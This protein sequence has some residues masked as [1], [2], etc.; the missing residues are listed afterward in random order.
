M[1]SAGGQYH[2][3]IQQIFFSA[4]GQYHAQIQK[5]FFLRVVNIM[6]KYNNSFFC[7]WS[8]SCTN[9]TTLFSAGGQYHAQIR[10]LFSFSQTTRNNTQLFQSKLLSSSEETKNLKTQMAQNITHTNQYNSRERN[11]K[12]M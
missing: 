12:Q 1:I 11:K 10:Q 6:H 3:Q 7:G 4:D 9:T 2:A 5:H 8:I